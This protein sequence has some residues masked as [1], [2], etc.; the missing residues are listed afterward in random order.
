MMS[1]QL[2]SAQP[3]RESKGISKLINSELADAQTIGA[4]V[5][6]TADFPI[7]IVR[8]QARANQTGCPTQL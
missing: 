5:G 6:A 2:T 1:L 4:K 8:I 7:K 3:Q